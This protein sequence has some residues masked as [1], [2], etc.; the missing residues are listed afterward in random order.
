MDR[1]A[2]SS[3][4]TTSRRTLAT[5]LVCLAVALASAGALAHHR[6]EFRFYPTGHSVARAEFKFPCIPYEYVEVNRKGFFSGFEP[7]QAILN[8]VWTS[9]SQREERAA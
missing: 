6:V 8:D 7:V 3:A 2:S 9:C 5:S 4:P 1:P